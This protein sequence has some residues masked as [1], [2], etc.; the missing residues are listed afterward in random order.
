MQILA[1]PAMYLDSD[2]Y[3]LAVARNLD[4]PGHQGPELMFGSCFIEAAFC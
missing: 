1:P 3:I 4:N 2:D